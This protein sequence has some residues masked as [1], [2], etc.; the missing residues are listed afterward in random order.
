MTWYW[1]LFLYFALGAV[2]TAD[3]GRRRGQIREIRLFFLLGGVFIAVIA[4]FRYQI[5]GDW[6]S[7][8]DM[9]EFAK[10]GTFWSAVFRGDPGYQFLN[11]YFAQAGYEVWTVN[12]VCGIIFSWGLLRFCSTQPNPW[13][14]VLVAVPYLIVVVA[15]GYTR[16][17]AALG[18]IMAGLA[19]FSKRESVIRF[20]MYVAVAALFHATA[21][22]ALVLVLMTSNRNRFL[23]IVVAVI[24]GLL[25]YR[26]F[27]NDTMDRFVRNYVDARYSSSG[28]L[29]RVGISAFAA[30]IF[31][32]ANR[33]LG[34][35]EHERRLWRNYSIAT[36]IALVALF[37]TPSSTAVDRLALYLIPLQVAVLSRFPYMGSRELVGSTFAVIAYSA[38][39]MFGWLTYATNARNWVP[40]QFYP[41]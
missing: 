13:L 19:D 18:V 26:F 23:N 11:W 41:L 15:L 5:G 32:Y 37:V 8:L 28:A 7:Y 16:Q 25:L 24:L 21:V 31:L 29:I 9:F 34:Y 40:Y 4:G 38:V 10:R 17:A 39:I 3:L 33:K 6:F 36:M 12:F 27:L 35:S 30:T 1:V 2:V 20:G 22:A 14:G